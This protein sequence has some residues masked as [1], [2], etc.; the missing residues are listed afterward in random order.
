[1]ALGPTI[2]LTKE[3][4]TVVQRIEEIIDIEIANKYNGEKYFSILLSDCGLSKVPTERVLDGLNTIYLKA[5]WSG[6]S[7]GLLGCGL[8]A[9]TLINQL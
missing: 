8:E 2:V 1:M 4:Q 7:T 3:E 9:F 5:G 6:F